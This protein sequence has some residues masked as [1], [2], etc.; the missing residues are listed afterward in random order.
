MTPGEEVVKHALQ[1]VG[2]HE[3]NGTNTGSPQPD[4]WERRVYGSIGVPWCACYVS[5]MWEDI[6]GKKNLDGLY[7]AS[8]QLMFDTARAKGLMLRSPV[9]GCAFVYPGVHIGLVT[10]VLSDRVISSVE[11]NHGDAVATDQRAYGY[12]TGLYF[13]APREIIRNSTPELPP[14]RLYYVE[15]MSAEPILRGPWIG[16]KRR[17]AKLRSLSPERRKAARPVDLGKNKFGFLEG[18]RRLYGPY[19]KK[20]QRDATLQKLQAKFPGRPFRAVSKQH[21]YT[22]NSL[23]KTT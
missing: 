11:G 16:R 3:L 23:G 15:D 7:S 5:S 19:P 1:F 17:D 14:E 12:G 6:L 18:P 13:I 20:E 22:A 8:T 2:V 21:S 4:G 10:K 9:V